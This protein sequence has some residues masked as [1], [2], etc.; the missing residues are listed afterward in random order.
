M[1]AKAASGLKFFSIR[2]GSYA[3]SFYQGCFSCVHRVAANSSFY[4]VT[5]G[6]DLTRSR[7]L[8]PDRFISFLVSS[9]SSSIRLLSI[10]NGKSKQAKNRI[11]R[12]RSIQ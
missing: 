1:V 11:N 6:K 5:P 9:G 8:E 10:E 7:K 4:A 12:G 2:R 3:V